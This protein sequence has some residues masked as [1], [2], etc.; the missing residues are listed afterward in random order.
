MIQFVR[1]KSPEDIVSDGI[2]LRLDGDAH[3]HRSN[4][5]CLVLRLGWFFA[6]SKTEDAEIG[7]AWILAVRYFKD[8]EFQIAD[9][10]AFFFYNE[11]MRQVCLCIG[12]VF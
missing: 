8:G 2:F 1:C 4:A 6:V 9:L 5:L 3:I 12:F 7:N 11:I 10:Y